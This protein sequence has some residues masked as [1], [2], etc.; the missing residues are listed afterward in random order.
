MQTN[1]LDGLNDAQREA[2]ETVDGPVLILAGAG[3]GKTKT[4][5]TRLAHLLSIGIPP[6]NT[7][8]LTFTNKA[9]MEMRERALKLI[10]ENNIHI[11]FP[12]KLFT[13][14]KFGLLFLR[15]YMK[16]LGRDNLKNTEAQD[17]S[18]SMELFDLT[19]TAYEN[20]R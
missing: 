18:L 12:P 9:A 6:D 14:H 20:V 8:T 1:L 17:M 3:T 4:I 7:L 19:W 16:E 13:F 2:A 5:T 11:G 15:F 10:E